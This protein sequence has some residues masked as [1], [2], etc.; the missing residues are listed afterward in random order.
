M[1]RTKLITIICW[2]VSALALLGLIIWVL[3]GNMFTFS[4]G[5]NT[6]PFTPATTQSVNTQN[7][8]TI[9]IDWTAGAIYVRRHQGNEIIVTELTQRE[10][11]DREEMYVS[12]SGGVLSIRYTQR[13]G[14]NIGINNLSKRL[15]VLVP[16]SMAGDFQGFRIN[17][18]SGR[19]II[20]DIGADNFSIRTNS[21]RIELHNITATTFS[22][23][24][25][26]GR[27]EVF[28]IYAED[29]STRT[30]SGRIEMRDIISNQLS[31]T[32]TSGRIELFTVEAEDINLRTNSGMIR[33]SDTDAGSITTQTSSGRHELFGSFGYVNARSNSGR[34]EIVSDI[35]PSHIT[36][37]ATSGRID[38][39]VPNQEPI[40]VQYSTSS[41]RFSS[42]IPTIAHSGANAQ[43]NLSTSSG[44]ISIFQR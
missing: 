11:R 42:E 33:A 34:L 37:R 19:V 3:V 39:T 7:I 20:S 32:T 9:D 6:G 5:F 4:F 23:T 15:E 24:T 8:H 21:G 27:V 40:A 17:N 18:T 1:S 22:A 16:Y 26:S 29:I 41:G 44:R 38:V 31:A 13:G 12:T 30:N 14:I 36:A 35:V 2:S 28:N 43:F 25:T 10:L